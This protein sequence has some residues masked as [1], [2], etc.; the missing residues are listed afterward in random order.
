MFMR[1]LYLRG[2]GVP[3]S[4]L[5]KKGSMTIE[6]QYKNNISVLFYLFFRGA[7]A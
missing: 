1:L 2:I 5:W 7:I 4:F 3:S 6:Y